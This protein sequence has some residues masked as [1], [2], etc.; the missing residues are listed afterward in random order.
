[1]FLQQGNSQIV[2]NDRTTCIVSHVFGCWRNQVILKEAHQKEFPG[3]IQRWSPLWKFDRNHQ[4]PVVR[5][6]TA[7]LLE[8]QDNAS[9]SSKGANIHQAAL[10]IREDTQRTENKM[11]FVSRLE[12]TACSSRVRFVLA[13]ITDWK[14]IVARWRLSS[15]SAEVDEILHPRSYFWSVQR[16]D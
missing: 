1:M 13:N 5:Y 15:K 8:R 11:S 2:W 12:H 9:Q 3:R 16:K 7:L 14:Q 6:I 10:D 4:I